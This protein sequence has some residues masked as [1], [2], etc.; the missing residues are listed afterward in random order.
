MGPES[1]VS[2]Q[3]RLILEEHP[4]CTVPRMSWLMG[5]G[6]RRLKYHSMSDT[7]GYFNASIWS[8]FFES[9]CSLLSREMERM[10]GSTCFW[11]ERTITLTFQ[12]SWSGME[13]V[14][15]VRVPGVRVFKFIV[16]QNK[17]FFFLPNLILGLLLTGRAPA[18]HTDSSRFDSSNG[19]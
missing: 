16:K 4:E 11:L 2:R 6:S 17:P 19:K 1:W 10:T 3:R 12:K 8:F 13:N 14:S 15:P 7:F 5:L 9:R 18:Y